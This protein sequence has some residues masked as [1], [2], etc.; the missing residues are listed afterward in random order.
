MLVGRSAEIDRIDRLIDALDEGQSGALVLRGEAGIGKSALLQ[1]AEDRARAREMTVLRASGVESE[2]ELAFCALADLLQ[3]LLGDLGRLAGPQGAALEGALELGPPLPGDRFAIA[4]ATFSLLALA[5]EGRPIVAL[6][7]DVQWLDGPSLSTLV[8]AVRRLKREGVLIILAA[9]EDQSSALESLDTI[10]LEGLDDLAARALLEMHEP[11]LSREVAEQVQRVASGNPLALLEV[12]RALSD[13]QRTG[14]E[15][16][17][18]PLKAGPRLSQIYR[19]RLRAL[20]GDAQQCLLVASAS[21]LDDTRSIARALTEFGLEL[22]GLEEAEEAGLVSIGEGRLIWRHPLVRA[23]VYHGASPGARRATHRALASALDGESEADRRA[24]HLAS[25]ALGDDDVAASALERSA[26]NAR[27]RRGNAAAGRAFERAARLSS[28]P[29]ERAR[30]L[31][32]AALDLLTSAQPGRAGRL[33]AEALELCTQTLLRADIQ[34]TRALVDMFSGTPRPLIEL[35]IKESDRVESE[36]PV[37][38]AWMRSDA[39][40]AATMTG[41]VGY[42]LGLAFHALEAARRAGPQAVTMSRAMLANALILAGRRK[43]AIGHLSAVREVLQSEGLPPF[44][45]VLLFVQALGHSSMWLEQNDEA[46]IFLDQVMELART[47]GAVRGTAFPLSCQSE[48]AYRRGRWAEAFAIADAA[49][50]I[51]EDV[52]ERNESSFSLVCMAQ[53]EAA[54]GRED[55]C[56]AHVAESLKISGELGIGSIEVYAQSAL[57]L[58]ELSLGRPDAALVH[59]DPLSRLAERYQLNEPNVVRWAPDFVEA[60]A[61]SGNVMEA[62]S[63]L[64]I[65]DGR[66]RATKGPWAMGE[67]ARCRGLLASDDDFEQCFAE[68][69]RWHAVGEAPFEQARTLLSLG[70]RRRRAKRA[71]GAREPLAR[72]LAS[73]EKLGATPWSQ[74]ALSELRATGVRLGSVSEPLLATLTPQE[75]RVAMAVG[76]GMTNRKAAAAL[77][78]SPKTVDYHLGKVYRKLNVSSRG[79]LAAIVAKH[80]RTNEED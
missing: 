74:R 50:Q 22:S 1:Y 35:L 65:F 28:D 60:H 37:R 15:P 52:G 36:D 80:A 51:A 79:E 66:A 73:F 78:L 54:W 16:L 29:E 64:S 18:E 63:A 14:A 17:D 3:P 69:I 46:Q 23:V 27:L 42:T 71:A 2:V 12:S 4:T 43:E 8:F 61:R 70:E 5:A 72:A 49:R 40:M 41:D 30:R 20:S 62:R 44:P 48:I 7:D 76:E 32:E 31:F 45:F 33:L 19:Q 55:D 39:C 25:A 11:T 6:V 67:S 59:L 38:A 57:G 68:A 34:R 53:V 13:A 26:V 75:L 77:F 56:R 24:W 21:D 47:H 10:L 58:L 9:R